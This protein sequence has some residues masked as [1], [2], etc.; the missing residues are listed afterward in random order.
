M[1]KVIPRGVKVVP[2]PH[3][4]VAGMRDSVAQN[5]FHIRYGRVDRART[6]RVYRGEYPDR[7]ELG[8]VIGWFGS[9]CWAFIP[10]KPGDRWY[11][12]PTRFEA[13]NACL[14]LYPGEVV[15]P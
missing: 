11:L 3:S 8:V 14:N 1:T 10:N 9:Q 12:A 2:R 13:I 5:Q 4:R 7:E 15:Q 6:F